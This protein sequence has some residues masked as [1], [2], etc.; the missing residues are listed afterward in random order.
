MAWSVSEKKAEPR[1][2]TNTKIVELGADEKSSPH[3]AGQRSAT[4]GRNLGGG[5]EVLELDFLLGVSLLLLLLSQLSLKFCQLSLKRLLPPETVVFQK[6]FPA[7]GSRK[8]G[9]HGHDYQG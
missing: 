2:S 1:K 9:L 5:M 7:C 4:S 6:F 8:L 3:K